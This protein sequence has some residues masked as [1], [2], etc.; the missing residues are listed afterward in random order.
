MFNWDQ[1]QKKGKTLKFWQNL[2]QIKKLFSKWLS[3]IQLIVCYFPFLKTFNSS[4]LLKW[5]LFNIVLK[6]L[7]YTQILHIFPALSAAKL[8]FKAALCFPMLLCCFLCLKY[9]LLT[10]AL[11][12]TWYYWNPTHSWRS[13]SIITLSIKLSEFLTYLDEISSFSVNSWTL[14]INLI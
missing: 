10:V 6:V 7:Y 4:R 8:L 14:I 9:S 5:K 1:G 2:I 11:P 3:K 13:R 12:N